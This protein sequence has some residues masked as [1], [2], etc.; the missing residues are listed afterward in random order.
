MLANSLVN[1]VVS[2]SPTPLKS[3]GESTLGP[4][5]LLRLSN[6]S[7]PVISSNLCNSHQNEENAQRLIG[8]EKLTVDSCNLIAISLIR[9]IGILSQERPPET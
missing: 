9:E 6:C 5:A 8:L 4:A 1:A 7:F 2:A 3:V